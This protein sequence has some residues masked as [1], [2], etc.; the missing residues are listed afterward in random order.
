[1][2]LASWVDGQPAASLPVDDRGLA[3]GDGVFE[4]MRVAGGR[5]ALLDGHL[6]RLARGTDVLRLPLDIEAMQQEVKD[7]VAAQG[8]AGRSDFTLKVIVTRGSAGRG[9]RPL[10]E[11]VPRRL[12][13]AYP[14]SV[15]PASHAQDGIAVHEC[16]TRLGSN[17][18][19]AG[20]KHL[21][22]LDQ[23]LAR[24]EWGDDPRWAEGLM[25]DADGRVIEGTMSNLFLVSDG[26]L[27]TPRLHRC[28]IAGVMRGFIVARA[29]TL[30]IAVAE[31]DVSREE[32][33]GCSEWFVCNS[34]IGIW[35]VR[36]LGSRR[37]TPGP[38]TRRLQRE[39]ELLWSR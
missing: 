23:V 26:T 29:L 32:L 20:L 36:E 34:T 39:I 27:V 2:L 16:A 10:P 13:L 8:T 37:W 18:A 30:G 28:G 22:R 7:F 11:A 6:Q 25:R 31:R 5:V 35:P 14:P 1:M 21:N 38:M 12:L 9:Y 33:D 19:L 24:A 3:Y 4:T 15:Q 17:P